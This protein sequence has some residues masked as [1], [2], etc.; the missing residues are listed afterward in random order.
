MATELTPDKLIENTAEQLGVSAAVLREFA[1]REGID[2][3]R[4]WDEKQAAMRWKS[5]H[6]TRG[7]LLGR[8]SAAGTTFVAREWRAG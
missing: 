6:R 8:V 4:F 2:P 3:L 5:E 1:A 7:A